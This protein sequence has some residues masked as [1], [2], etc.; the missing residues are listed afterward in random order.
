MNSLTKL[1]LSLVFS[2]LSGTLAVAGT[3][4][5]IPLSTRVA[6]PPN[7]MLALSVEFPTANTA[8]YQDASSYSANSKY[9][10]YFDMD[11]C[12]DYDSGNGWFVPQGVSTNRR[13]SGGLFGYWSGNFLN[14]A[15]MTGLDE[16]RFAMTGGNRSSDTATLT[17]LERTYQS[18]Q[19]GTANFPDKTFTDGPGTTMPFGTGASITIQNQ[20]RGIQMQ[21][22]AAGSTA[23]VDCLSPSDGAGSP[24]IN[25]TFTVR[26]AVDT[27][28]CTAWTGSGTLASPYRCT[29]FSGF[30][31]GSPSVI[32]PQT[33]AAVVGLS[34]TNSVTCANPTLSLTGLFDC[35]LTLNT[36]STATCS[37]WLGTG[38]AGDPFRC[39]AFTS[40]SGGETFYPNGTYVVATFTGTT[41]SPS[42]DPSS[43]G[44]LTC[45][46]ASGTP[47]VTTCPLSA[48]TGTASCSAYSGT[49]TS[50][51][52]YV[53]TS[54][55][56]DG[57]QVHVS[58]SHSTGSLVQVAS[59]Y[60]ASRYRLTYNVPN[61]GTQSYVSSYTG[62][63]SASPHYY[64][65]AYSVV[66]G[67][68]Q[69][70]NVRV[71]VCDAAFPESNCKRYGSSLKPTGALQDSSDKVRFGVTSYFQAN[72]VDN[73]VLRSKMKYI[74]PQQFSAASGLTANPLAEFSAADGTL[75]THPD[76]S[77]AATNNSYIG[78]VSNSGVINYINKFGSASHTYKTYDVVGK[79]Y[80]ETLNYFRHI[81]P[82][83]RYYQGARTANADG[84][85][86]ITQWDDPIQ[87]SCQ[88]NY[89]LMMGDTHTWCDKRLP[90]GTHGA[91]NNSVCNAYTD[92]NANA[93]TADLGS[94]SGDSGVNV[95][96]E[97]NLVGTT[98][99]MGN[100]ATT[101]TGAGNS[102]GFGMA[103]LA[104]WAARSDIRPGTTDHAEKQTVQTLIV[105]V[106]E[107][108]DCGYQSQF[109][110]AAK[111]G[112]PDSYGTAGNWTA[113][114]PVWSSSNSLPAGACASRAPPGYNAGGGAVTWPKN[115]LRAGDPL[116]MISS[117]RNAIEEIIREI[118]DEAAL[119]QSSGNLDTG[120]GAYL[121]QAFFVSGDWTGEVQALPVSQTGEVSAVPAWKASAK[122]PAHG[123]RH[124]FTFNDATR[125]GVAFDPASFT[126][127]FSS[128]QQAFLDANEFG[129]S[130]GR[131][132]DRVAY[133]R[134]DQS[135]EATLAGTTTP[136]A[137]GHGWR[138][139][140]FQNPDQSAVEIKLLGDV[141][142]SN[143]LFV[144]PPAAGYSDPGYREF[145]LSHA[146][147][148]P[149]LYVGGNDGMLHGYDADFK[150][151]SESGGLPVAKV[152]SGTEVF[153]YVPAA[154]YR[155]LSQLTAPSYSH[156]FFV[157]GSP[158]AVDAYFG[159]ATASWK[160][161]LVGG[162]NAGGQGI[163]ALDVTNPINAGDPNT[164]NFTA[165]NVLWEFNDG[166]DADLGFT[167]GRPLVRKLND[168]NW[169]VIFGSGYNNSYAD[170]AAGNGRAHLFILKVEG[171]GAGNPW[172]LGTNYFKITV[173]SPSEGTAPTLPLSPANGLAFIAGLNPD[174]DGT[175]DYIYGGDR[176]GNLWKFDLSDDDPSNWKVAFGTVASPLPLFTATD[177]G[178]AAQ[179]IT[180]G[181]ELL[182]HP[183]GGYFVLFGTGSWV[184]IEDPL[185]NDAQSF[186]GIWDKMDGATR[187]SSRSLLQRQKVVANL[188]VSL[189]DADLDG[190]I[191]DTV[192][193]SCAYGSTGCSPVYSACQP[194]Y[195]ESAADSNLSEPLCPSDI[196]FPDGTDVQLGWVF[197][198]PG[199]GERTRSSIP[200]LQ[201]SNIVFTTLTPTSADPCT[202]STTGVEH[203]LS[204]RTGGTPT[205]P[206]FIL[207]G[208]ESNY[209][210]LPA[211]FLGSGSAAVRVVLGGRTLAG[212]GSELGTSFNAR[213]PADLV[214]PVAGLP[215][216]PPPGTYCVGDGCASHGY[217]SG[218]GFVSNLVRGG[219]YVLVCNPSGSVVNCVFQTKSANIGR[220][221]WKQIEH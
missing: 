71:K 172:V 75:V 41:L 46:V 125:T 143:P 135:K 33:P 208:H 66:F 136:N 103:G 37:N 219:K 3:V 113:G 216:A 114:N 56:Y 205:S 198:L 40:F 149:A 169:Y 193:T 21:A 116:S 65:S 20:G 159:G 203:H 1:A 90:G 25:C 83:T 57:T 200:R 81:S 124:I 160:T 58:N 107:Y 130:D 167:F 189:E 17:V 220:I 196:A 69:T 11:K 188:A 187:V 44:R 9:L 26:G 157:D 70:F 221:Q 54:F 148:V 27:G 175:T 168:G 82:T 178:G 38:T 101:Y 133:L 42:I 127:N 201:G 183:N 161:L 59:K 144:G 180:T 154:V 24:P 84:F 93:H 63:P 91:A 23:T 177:A 129:I 49:G 132:A 61:T 120:T 28:N 5:D 146:N 108:R 158:V 110:L 162:L 45:T 85:P 184:D 210:N 150:V 2:V 100:I 50:S 67:A 140:S 141:V 12:Y 181:L 47:V 213:P 164:S 131:G 218:F 174:F 36:G 78:T 214:P 77:D 102:A 145:A 155:N 8:A 73:A 128:A 207:S 98:E 14:W 4:A 182:S 163:Y 190:A 119:A 118:G 95:T 142:N 166:D 97:M 151:T 86:V 94:L 104:G 121:Y 10:G 171:P 206:V 31:G 156:K 192:V 13:C 62:G 122:L 152:S 30:A 60:Y 64:T 147:R 109:W 32:T 43:T 55:G 99:G 153:A 106:E 209:I 215:A 52:P 173:K 35:S 186:Y 195:T 170:G 211:G 202:A 217:V 34:N 80:Y 139:R 134:G 19:G 79:L 165:S 87:Y 6:V 199:T 51:N 126:T 76:A 16:F 191:D 179:Q 7:V 89:I 39:G 138:S 22:A 53:C 115:L 74:G 194:N 68:A 15:T 212:G 72:D 197:D 96:S 112:N 29:A 88:K 185:A 137:S 18:G 48:T 111:Y 204:Y 123:S 117:V 92:S 105:D 176:S